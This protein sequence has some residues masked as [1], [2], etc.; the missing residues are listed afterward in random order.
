MVTYDVYFGTSSPPPLV[1]E[2]LIQ[3]AYDPGTMDLNT[4]YY[5]QIVVWDD[6]GSSTSGSIWSFT[7]R[8]NDPPNEP[9]DPDPED[10]ETDVYI[11]TDVSWTGGDPDGDDV[12]YDVY[13]GTSSPPPKIKSNQSGTSYN[14]QGVLDFDTTY[15]WQIVA[16]DIFN[17]TSTG[18]IWSFTTEANIPP[19]EPSDPDPEDGATDVY[20]EDI[21]KWTGGDPNPGDMVTYDVYFGTSSPPPLVV[22][23]LIQAAY[24][25][26]TM[27]LNTM[28]YWQ[29]V[30]WDS[31]D[32]STTGPIWHFTTE[33]EQNQP[34]N[35]PSIDGST[36]GKAGEEYDYTFS[37]IDPNDDVVYY[38]IEWGDG[39]I[40]DWI[41]SY[42]SGE[43]VI[44][45]HSWDEQKT[46]TI[47]AKAKD[48]H[49]A[50]SDWTTLEVTM[51]KNKPFIQN[52]PL[53]NWLFE[54]FPNMF[55]ILRHL[56]AL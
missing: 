40:E 25:P 24:D 6:Q 53:L 22:E 51:P 38:Y 44:I 55:P 10:G 3:A 18:S 15:Y 7:T 43:E 27:D 54:R 28:Y 16:W 1:V 5:W 49:D 41:G 12:T 17:Y 11:N 35:E 23:D 36:S 56:L 19:N 33:L 26:G 48:S 13:F 34:P 50:E 2:D 52:F 42:D 32:L 39:N 9:S 8:G 46:Y 21:L 14:P 30:A 20:I 47:R 37:V 45:S 31:Q 29:I 4:M